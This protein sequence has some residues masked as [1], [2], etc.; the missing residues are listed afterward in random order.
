MLS[1]KTINLRF[2][3]ESDAEF[4]LSLRTDERYNKYLSS[5]ANDINAQRE[6]IKNYKNK[7]SQKIEFYFI[8]ERNDGVPCGTVRIY[9]FKNDSFSWGSWIL[10]D[11]KP[12][13][14]AVESAFLIYEFGFEKL[15]FKKSH[16]EVVKGNDKVSDFHLKFGA[17]QVDEDSDNYYYEISK[18]VVAE[19]KIKFARIFK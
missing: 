5:V 15:G 4:I 14:A 10:N 13:Y 1:S 3:E 7:E 19:N 18:S 9:D 2:V 12:R 11:S 8:I 6:W 16:F 17:Q